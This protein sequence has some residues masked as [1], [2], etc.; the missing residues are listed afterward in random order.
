MAEK[1][2]TSY[3]GAG[4]GIGAAIGL[5]F[6]LLLSENFIFGILIGAAAGL[7]IGSIIDAQK[8]KTE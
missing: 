7:I 2:K 8:N 1:K 3:A 6:G 4:M 5:I